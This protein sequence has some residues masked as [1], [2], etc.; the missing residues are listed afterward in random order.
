M[1]LGIYIFAVI[2]FTLMFFYVQMN[3]NFNRVF[4]TSRNALSVLKSGQLTDEDKEK[5]IQQA[6]FDLFKQA[7]FILVKGAFV[8]IVTSVP[9]LLADFLELASWS[10]SVAFSLRLDVLM[11]TL[12]IMCAARFSYKYLNK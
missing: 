9:F 1:I 8:I 3:V 4:G 6:A 11:Y 2:S 5:E 7:A 10:E 12:V